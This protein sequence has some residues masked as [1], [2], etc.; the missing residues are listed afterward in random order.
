MDT[1]LITLFVFGLIGV[2]LYYYYTKQKALLES[3]QMVKREADFYKNEEIFTMKPISFE[4]MTNAIQNADF[5]A[6]R[7]SANVNSEKKYIVFTGSSFHAVLQEKESTKENAVY[8]FSLHDWHGRNGAAP[9]MDINI[10]MTAVEKAIL[11]PDPETKVTSAP[12][13]YKSKTSLF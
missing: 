5:S 1:F 3:G 11:G 12:I 9:I 7:V 4:E 13:N 8:G 6:M 10:L 2:A